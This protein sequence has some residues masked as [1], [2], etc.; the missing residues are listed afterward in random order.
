MK[1]AE[2]NPI[3]RDADVLVIDDEDVVVRGV[4]RILE[5]RGLRAAMAGDMATAL[6]HPAFARCRLVVCDLMLPQH[7]GLEVMRAIRARRPDLPI[8]MIT[9]LATPDSVAVAL[10]TGAVDV[11]PK[12]FDEDELLAMIDRVLPRSPA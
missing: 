7:S 2:T 12:P 10:Q 3:E 8:I 11:L 1:P 9:G 6:A 4:G 5:S